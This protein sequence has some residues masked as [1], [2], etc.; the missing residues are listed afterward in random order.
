MKQNQASTTAAGIALARA[1]ESA[2]PAGERICYDPFARRFIS[3]AFYHFG[4]FFVDIGYSEWK[5]PGVI[6]FLV[7]R[8]RYLD[9]YMQSC[10][11]NGLE[12]LVI[13]GA[14]YDSRAYRLE[15]LIAGP[16]RVFE[17]D[18]PATQQVKREQLQ[19]ILGRLPEHVIYVPID[20]TLET[21]ENRL[22]DSGYDPQ[23]KTLFTWEG[24]TQYLT[25]D[26]VDSTLAF[27]AGHSGPGSAIIFDYMYTS[28]LDGTVTRGEVSNMRRYRRFTG[29]GLVFGI[30]EGTV[31]A[32]LEQRGFCQVRNVDADWLIK[33]Y[34]T[35]VNERRQVAAGYAIVSATVKTRT[36]EEKV[37]GQGT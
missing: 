6:G 17:V 18:H 10:L 3:G 27:V 23:A 2:K 33:T 11:D 24:V 1:I 13:L 26:A 16:V 9:D 32:F 25:P 14:G 28:L 20:F 19:K 36:H 34:F 7:A 29:E 15:K 37:E 8:V 35:G 5:G 4:K 30:P 12:Q 21:L 22:S 31:A